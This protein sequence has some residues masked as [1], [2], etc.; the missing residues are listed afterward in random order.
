MYNK[1]KFEISNEEK[2]FIV[3][4]IGTD[5]KI[6][7]QETLIEILDFK[8]FCN[9]YIIEQNFIVNYVR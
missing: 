6:Y 9:R 4:I 8:E 3:E 7:N 1:N 2:D 5:Y